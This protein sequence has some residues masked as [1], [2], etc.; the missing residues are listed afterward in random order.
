M[1]PGTAQ[2]LAQQL[3]QVET[4]LAEMQTTFPLVYALASAV[5]LAIALALREV[6]VRY[7]GLPAKTVEALAT[8][9]SGRVEAAADAFLKEKSKNLARK[10]DLNLILDEV[11]ATRVATAQIEQEFA[12]RKFVSERTYDFA[13]KAVEQL[14]QPLFVCLEGHERL[15]SSVKA[16][17]EERELDGPPVTLPKLS[18]E[19]RVALYK[20]CDEKHDAFRRA[21]AMA[22]VVLGHE[23]VGI[24]SDY[25]AEW[26]RLHSVPWEQWEDDEEGHLNRI[27]GIERRA[28]ENLCVAARRLLVDDRADG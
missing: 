26:A 9:V 7:A 8:A 11:K 25:D 13:A 20:V 4:T 23:V 1:D 21:R 28:Y 5:L 6:F 16:D 18:S 10:A 3:A 22:P 12:K 15:L 17:R 2:D 14:I 19:D 27:V 24:L